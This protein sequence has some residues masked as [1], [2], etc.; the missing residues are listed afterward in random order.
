FMQQL[1]PTSIIIG[2]LGTFIGLTL[3]ISS[4]QETLMFLSQKPEDANLNLASVIEA[5]SSP[6]Q[7]MSVAFIT[8]IAGIGN[9][10]FLTL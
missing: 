10:L 4:M 2:I 9:A 6:F 3:A 1:P 8:S 7:G 5:I